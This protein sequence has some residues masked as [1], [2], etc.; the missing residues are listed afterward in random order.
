MS[1]PATTI[2]FRFADGQPAQTHVAASGES[3]LDVALNNGIQLQHNCGGVCGCSTCHIYVNAGGDDL[4]EISDKEEDF[5]DRAENPRI[6]SRLACQ[7]V[8]EA[9]MQLDVTIPPQHFLG[10]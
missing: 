10:H 6:N 8:V 1:V 4:P 2:T 9:N 5:I 7:C 3:V